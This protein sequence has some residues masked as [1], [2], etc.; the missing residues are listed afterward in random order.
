MY[1]AFLTFKKFF[2]LYCEYIK[3]IHFSCYKMAGT[4]QPRAWIR[5]F[6]YGAEV[7]MWPSLH[8]KHSFVAQGS[9]THCTERFFFSLSS[10]PPSMCSF[11]QKTA[12]GVIIW[13]TSY[14]QRTA[15]WHNNL[16][17]TLL[18]QFT[19]ATAAHWQHI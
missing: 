6:C 5:Y 14:F 10:L 16:L 19:G 13:K 9:N 3:C 7:C 17:L 11:P 12:T 15:P 1:F 2:K 4:R 18:W 8:G